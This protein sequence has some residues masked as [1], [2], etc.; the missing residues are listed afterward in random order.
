MYRAPL[1]LQLFTCFLAMPAH[2]ILLFMSGACVHKLLT[3]L[4][5]ISTIELGPYTI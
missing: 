3:Q 1:S 4:V 5:S 2:V